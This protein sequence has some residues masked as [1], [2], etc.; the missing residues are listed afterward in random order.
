[1]KPAHK[2]TQVVAVVCVAGAFLASYSKVPKLLEMK[3]LG[4]NLYNQNTCLGSKNNECVKAE[5]DNVI[6]ACRSTVL[7]LFFFIWKIMAPFHSAH[8]KGLLH[9]FVFR[10]D[11]IRESNCRHEGVALAWNLI[12]CPLIGRM[13]CQGRWMVPVVTPFGCRMTKTADRHFWLCTYSGRVS[14]AQWMMVFSGEW[15][16]WESQALNLIWL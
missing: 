15:G 9:G 14:D 11:P 5:Y 13:I 3:R 12:M 1:M 4:Y 7:L 8:P 16:Q 2:Q 10:V 6:T